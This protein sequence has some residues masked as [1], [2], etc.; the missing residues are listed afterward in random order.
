MSWFKFWKTSKKD[1]KRSRSD[2]LRSESFKDEGTVNETE[3]EK[4]A[5]LRHTMSISRSG[6]FKQKNKQRAAILDKPE[7][8]NDA[9]NDTSKK[10]NSANSN[11][12]N[13]SNNFSH[14]NRR[15]PPSTCRDVSSRQPIT[16]RHFE[17]EQTVL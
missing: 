4:N 17:G 11:Q 8:F 1:D 2:I 7:F 15:T 14:E 12:F 5:R 10:E 3:K 9:G 16:S 13:N 6:R